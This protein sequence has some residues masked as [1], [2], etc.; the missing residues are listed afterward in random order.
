MTARYRNHRNSV[1]NLLT[2]MCTRNTTRFSLVALQ[3]LILLQLSTSIYH[4]NEPCPKY[5]CPLAPPIHEI[6]PYLPAP[7]GETPRCAQP[8][9]T[10]CETTERYPRQL[11]KFLI[12]RQPISIEQFLRDESLENF[13][14]YRRNPDYDVGYDYPKPKT[15]PQFFASASASAVSQAQS[16]AIQLELPLNLTHNRYVQVPSVNTFFPQN[17]AITS[18]QSFGYQAN[19]QL[20]PQFHR[21]ILFDPNRGSRFKRDS[22]DARDSYGEVGH[23]RYENPLLNFAEQER[24]RAR[25]QSDSNAVSICPTRSQFVMPKAALNNQGKWMY[26][27]NLEEQAKY[28]QLVKSEVCISD[29]CDGLCSLPLGYSSKCQQQYVQ[30]RLVALDGKGDR[31]YTDVFWF[32][33]GCMCQV[34]LDY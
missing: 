21:P 14:A 2:I 19:L 32:P 27:V 5:G 12:E 16:S 20:H 30:K 3:L 15:T 9:L 1:P 17:A 24:N 22:R 29:T 25:R 23:T 18:Q 13:N 34:K 8:G 10:F 28:S 31:L 11:I 4:H 33:H 7:P 6:E 26:V